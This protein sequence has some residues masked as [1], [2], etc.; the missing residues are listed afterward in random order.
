M[1]ERTDLPSV[2][3]TNFAQRMRET[4]MTYL[5]RQGNPLD[6]GITLRD[7][8]DGGV[9]KLNPDA[10]LQSLG[11]GPI[12]IAPT[13]NN[14]SNT[15]VDLTAPPVPTVFTVTAG[16]TFL[17]IEIPAQTYTAGGGHY[18]THVY[19]AKVT[20]VLPNPTFSNATEISQFTAKVTSIATEPSTEWA[21]WLK[22][23]S[24]ANVLSADAGG[25][26]NGV[27]A[28]TGQDI[29]QLVD[30]MTGAGKPFQI[31]SAPI[32]LPDGTV[33]PAGTYTS[34]AYIK[35]GSIQTAKIADAAIT[36]AKI[37]NLSADKITAG[38]IA[39]DRLDA[40]V[41][42]AKV[43]DLQLAQIDKAS[44]ANLSA[45][46]ADLGTVTA[47]SM[48]AVTV[49][50]SDINGGTLTI[51]STPAISGTT[52]TGSGAKIYSDGRFALGNSS[53]NMVFDGT[54]AFINGFSAASTVSY[55]PPTYVFI[56]SGAGSFSLTSDESQ[57]LNFDPR[58]PINAV[59]AVGL[60]INASDNNNPNCPQAMTASI[61]PYYAYSSDG[62][63]TYSGWLAI[64]YVS[65]KDLSENGYSISGTN[66]NFNANGSNVTSFT[67]PLSTTHI[68]VKTELFVKGYVSRDWT[69]GN[70]ASWAVDISFGTFSMPASVNMDR[71]FIN[72]L[73]FQVKV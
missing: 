72:T 35:N 11:N 66:R 70:G 1:T 8:I 62:G 9:V 16:L 56:P 71:S 31:V 15:T 65:V 69:N 50:S 67:V 42:T 53:S 46:S 5:G 23:E 61:S 33:I 4:V 44:I 55:P 6:R 17:F 43:A 20:T 22:Y 49:N 32:T 64:T 37:A 10:S 18:R 63:S 34:D 14:T 57:F 73:L 7:L 47:G 38:T 28:T 25:G 60:Q 59:T 41:V 29:S 39:A 3:A 24:L 13:N 40:A 48:T 12:P 68:K 21:I 51:G 36:N 2:N 19:G 58:K 30:A 52:M 27:H 26:T 45:I 54:K